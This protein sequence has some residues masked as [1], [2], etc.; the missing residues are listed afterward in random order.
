MGFC[1]K[2]GSRKVENSCQKCDQVPRREESYG[3]QPY[4]Q[5]QPGVQQGYQQQGYQQP[6][7]HQQEYQ[8]QGYQQQ[9][10]QQQGYQQQGYQQ[11]GYQQQGY[12][13]QGVH[14]HGYHQQGI[15]EQGHQG[16]KSF[17]SKMKQGCSQAVRST[18]VQDLMSLVKGFFT[19]RPES[20][21]EHVLKINSPIWLV[22]GGVFI[23]LSV[24][25]IMATD[26]SIVFLRVF[27]DA[28]WG[29]I[30]LY[31]VFKAI[32]PFFL[33][34]VVVK[35]TL[36][37]IKVQMSFPGVLNLVSTAMIPAILSLMVG[38][39][40]SFFSTFLAVFIVSIGSIVSFIYLMTAIQQICG[41]IPFWAVVIGYIIYTIIVA[42][43][44]RFLLVYLHQ[45]D[46]GSMAGPWENII[47]LLESY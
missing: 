11:Q 46:V 30:F 41:R 33:L 45:G 19:K 38:L 43:I 40:F 36:Q 25:V 18:F 47:N 34:V 39:I 27:G 29:R 26:P 6:G 32:L 7:V 4:E 15:Q 23:L 13:Q 42:V 10:Y 21:F 37:T 8:Q 2:C 3:Q 28:S 22:L 44:V 17:T 35:I 20:A 31:S 12:Q 9:G 16:K 1:S 14:P 24:I 5:Q